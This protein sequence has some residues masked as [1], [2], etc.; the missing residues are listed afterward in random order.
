MIAIFSFNHDA[1]G[2]GHQGA[3]GG[4]QD[5]D[6]VHQRGEGEGGPVGEERDGTLKY[7]FTEMSVLQKSK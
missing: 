1:G 7:V 3:G 5:G 6:G 4:G 2:Q